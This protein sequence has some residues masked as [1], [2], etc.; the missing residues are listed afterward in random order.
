LKETPISVSGKE[1]HRGYFAN[2][3]EAARRY[4]ALAQQHHWEFACCKLAARN[5]KVGHKGW[6][7]NQQKQPKFMGFMESVEIYKKLCSKD[8]RRW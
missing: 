4:N 5:T 7:E 6:P 8:L 2:E 3:R 1:A